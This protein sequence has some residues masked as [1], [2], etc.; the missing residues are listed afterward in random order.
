LEYVT[1][2]LGYLLGN[3]LYDAYLEGRVGPAVLRRLFLT[4]LE[5]PGAAREAYANLNTRLR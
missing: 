5:E 4:H 2:Q 1:L 3:D